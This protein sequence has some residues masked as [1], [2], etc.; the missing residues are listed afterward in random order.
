MSVDIVAE[1]WW[2]IFVIVGTEDVADCRGVPFSDEE[3]AFIKKA[4]EDFEKSQDLIRGRLDKLK[5]W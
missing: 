5:K 2:D 3:I 1:E 4:K